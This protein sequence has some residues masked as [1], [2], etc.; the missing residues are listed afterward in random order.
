LSG[1]AGQAAI[2][3]NLHEAEPCGTGTSALDKALRV[4]IVGN[5]ARRRADRGDMA[6]IGLRR[7]TC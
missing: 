5:F 3:L 2:R 1:A 7:K 4:R 6:Q